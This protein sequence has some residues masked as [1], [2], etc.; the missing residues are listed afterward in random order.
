MKSVTKLLLIVN[1]LFWIVL[2]YTLTLVSIPIF[3]ANEANF[4]TENV[5]QLK[6]EEIILLLRNRESS[7]NSF[8]MISIYQFRYIVGS[9]GISFVYLVRLLILWKERSD[10]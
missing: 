6:K 8:Y 7:L 10:L 1:I 9:M 4:I 2:A 5:D 3:S